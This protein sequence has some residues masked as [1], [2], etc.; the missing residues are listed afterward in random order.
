MADYMALIQRKIKFERN[1]KYLIWG[2]HR[3]GWPHAFSTL[4]KA[5]Y[6]PDGVLCISAVEEWIGDDKRIDEPWIGFIHQV[7]KN[8]YPNYPDLERL[9]A[10]QHFIK[11]LG[12]CHG[13]FVLSHYV[14]SYLEKYVP[15]TLPITRV[16]YPITPFPDNKCFNWKAFANAKEKR[17]LFI[18]EHLRRYQ[19]FYDLKVPA[20][21]K[22][23]LLKAPGVDF[24]NLLD[25]NLQSYR[26]Q[27]ND[28]VT[29]IDKRISDEE[30]DDMLSS[31]IVFLSLYDAGANTI[32]I[33]CLTRGTPLVVNKLPGI[34]E[35]FGNDYPLY[36]DSLEEATAL[37]NNE[38]NLLNASEYLNSLDVKKKLECGHFLSSI[39]NSS[40]YLSLPVP[41]C[42]QEDAQ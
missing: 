40:I 39:I 10:N 11:S 16:P 14:K 8:N 15:I 3:G 33:E 2:H 9:V 13:I 19:S 26:L 7:P 41:V 12:A 42:Q 6:T 36:Y 24:N 25:C 4:M 31:S 29:L 37:L 38:V 32:V 23:Y 17:L 22:K 1:P 20:G 5:L 21:Y 35:Y 18:G 30:Y 27:L 34:V 28:S